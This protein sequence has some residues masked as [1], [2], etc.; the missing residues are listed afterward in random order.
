[1]SDGVKTPAAVKSPAVVKTPATVKPPAV[2]KANTPKMAL[3]L[4]RRAFDISAQDDEGWVILSALGDALQ[5]IEPSFDSRTY[6]FKSLSLLIKS[7]PNQFVVKGAK[8]T[9][10]STIYVHMKDD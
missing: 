2:A 8:K 1:M 6:G 4:L 9:G 7:L 10:T 5:R 3:S